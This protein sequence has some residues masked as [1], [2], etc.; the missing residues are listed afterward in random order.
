MST[1]GSDGE[2][3]AY[4]QARD[5]VKARPGAP[6]HRSRHPARAGMTVGRIFL[7]SSGCPAG[8]SAPTILLIFSSS[9]QTPASHRPE[10]EAD[11][12][13]RVEVRGIEVIPEADRHGHP[14]E[15]FFV[16]MTSNLTVLY[17]IFGGILISLGLE[18]W[19]AILAAIIGNVFYAL[20]GVAA[21]VGPRAGTST[22]M[23]SRAQYGHNGNRISSFFA[24][25]S[26]VGFEAINLAFGAFALF[27]MAGELGWDVGDFGKAVLLG[28]IVAVTFGVAVLGH[29]T[30]VR[31]QQL[32]ALGLGGLALLLIALTLGDVKWD[33][34]PETP[35]EGTAAWVA[36]SAGLTLILTGPLSW[37][38]VPA[39]FTR[40]MPS[41]SSPF[42]I[43]L[44]TTLGAITPALLLTL[45]GVLVSTAVDP[46]DL[47]TSIKDIVPG[48]FYPLFLAVVVLG[49]IA[50]NVLGI[51]SS[52][53]ALQ[54][55]GLRVHRAVAVSIDA[56]IGG[57][58]SVY[59]V[60]VSDFTAT[61]SEFL[62]WALFWW[63][64]YLAIFIVDLVLRRRSYDGPELERQRGGRYWYDGG[65]RW[66]AVAALVVGGVCTALFA[67]TT[68]LRGP[69]STE[70]L[71]GGDISALV[72]MAVGGSLYWAL[73]RRTTAADEPSEPAIARVA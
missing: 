23:V 50:N 3:K 62:Q 33:Y 66:R 70:L 31:F 24:W 1:P 6:A 72:G 65:F 12:V 45:L 47:I 14:R 43:T 54:S 28:L 48:W 30:I 13:G 21:T 55:L 32:F 57:G 58:M 8:G 61:L 42:Q 51:Y 59:A 22:L 68:H 37:C 4:L 9:G 67:Q 44:Y 11:R 27:A 40:Y 10:P 19:Q 34:R 41:N 36:F 73:C 64:P 7:R 60:F 20:I 35:L 29:A 38:P 49:T 56:V 69:L 26:L 16:W 46:A 17:L 52:G 71:S 39:D 18:L 63:A 53:L 5:T 15:L 2:R 25:L